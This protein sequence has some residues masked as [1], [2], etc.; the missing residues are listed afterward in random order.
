MAAQH[1]EGKKKRE[2]HF[3][4]TGTHFIFLISSSSVSEL[5]TSALKSGMFR[6]HY[7]FRDF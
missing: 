2:R 4:K 7:G 6:R 3:F 1:K 5:H